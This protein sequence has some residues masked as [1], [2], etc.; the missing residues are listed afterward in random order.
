MQLSLNC[1]QYCQAERLCSILKYLENLRMGESTHSFAIQK[2]L[3]V[4]L[5]EQVCLYLGESLPDYNDLMEIMS[6]AKLSKHFINLVD[7]YAQR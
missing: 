3:A 6:N 2:Q 4:I 7:I 1:G 5:A